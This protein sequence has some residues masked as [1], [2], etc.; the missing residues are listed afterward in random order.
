VL[1]GRACLNCHDAHGANVQYLL[2]ALPYDLCLSCHGKD[3]LVDEAGKPLPNMAKEFANCRMKHGPVEEKDCSA[4]HEV[5]GSRHFRLLLSEYPARFYAPWE[6]EN[7]ALCFSCH[8]S[9][10]FD[11]ERTTTLTGFRDGDWN[12]HF[13]HVH[14]LRRGRTCRACHDVH[15]APHVH[16][17]RDG[18]PYGSS[19]WILKINYTPTDHGGECTKT[20]HTT[21][22]YDRRG[23]ATP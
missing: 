2:P 15:A 18:V 19:G 10:V 21:R 22:V 13:L 3:G 1:E 7:Y 6:P 23:K 8:E 4:C 12:L 20:C 14:K 17:I 16:M 11:V 5:H 9:D